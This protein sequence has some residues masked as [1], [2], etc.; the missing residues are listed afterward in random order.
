[1][2]KITK[3]IER[4]PGQPFMAFLP[5]I[6]GC[7]PVLSALSLKS[8]SSRLLFEE[9]R[10]EVGTVNLGVTQHARLEKAGLVV[11]RRSSRRAAEGR[12]R[13]ALQAKQID[14]AELQ[15]VGIWSAV[16]QMAGL[17]SVDLHR[18]MLENKRPSFVGVALEAE[19]VLAGRDEH[20]TRV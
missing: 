5:A 9:S 2:T 12:R 13:M 18:L 1:M 15:H 6:A 4:T 16:S 19:R 3:G 17:T 8:K 14:V 7:I 20:L 11:E 10:I